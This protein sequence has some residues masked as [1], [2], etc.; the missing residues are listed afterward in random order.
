MKKEQIFKKYIV[1]HN[2]NLLF[3]PE[4]LIKN[5]RYSEWQPFDPA[6]RIKNMLKI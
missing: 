6:E 2:H 3:S 1:A 5:V 4:N